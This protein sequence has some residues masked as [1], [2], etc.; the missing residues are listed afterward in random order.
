MKNEFVPYEVA[1]KLK[2]FRI[3]S[4]Y[5]AYYYTLDGKVWKFAL[6]EMYDKIDYEL[7]IGSNFTVAAPLWQQVIDWLREIRHLHINFMIE[8]SYDVNDKTWKFEIL[9]TDWGGDRV[10]YTLYRGKGFKT[11]NEMR[12]SAICKSV[13]LI[14]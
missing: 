13:E 1:V 9:D 8:D 4:E 3:S 6:A 2:E 5:L 14:K 10:V 12:E 11:F 7:N